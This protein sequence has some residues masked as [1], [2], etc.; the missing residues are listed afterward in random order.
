MLSA[1]DPTLLL[2]LNLF[3]TVAFAL[4]G[5]MAGVRAKLDLF[6]V[7]VLAAVVGLAGGIARDLMLGI[8]PRTIQDWR[9]LAAVV[10][11]GL[12]T[13]VG[14]RVLARLE[15]PVDFLDACGL[16]IFCVTGAAA[17]LRH[18]ADPSEAVVL[19]MITAAGG[20][21]V[22]DLMLTEVPVVLRRGL[23]AVP[24]LLGA[25]V[26]VIADHAGATTWIWPVLG[27]A[28]C[29]AIRLAGMQFDINLPRPADRGR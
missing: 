7:L 14:H 5:A 9:F 20:G 2:V 1:L 24:A 28:I 6:G 18:D 22:R 29:L 13:A 15:R 10:I 25:S 11:A 19:G 21:I 3:G 12:A 17:A 16:A 26:F 4:S 8:A 27:G 23:Y